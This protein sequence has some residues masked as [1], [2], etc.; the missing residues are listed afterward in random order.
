MT[1]TAVIAGQLEFWTVEAPMFPAAPAA[2]VCEHHGWAH[3]FT[4]CQDAAGA[5]LTKPAE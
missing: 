3:K 5:P 2:P 1:T 4:S